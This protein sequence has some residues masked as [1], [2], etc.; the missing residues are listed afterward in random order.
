MHEETP[1]EALEGRRRVNKAALFLV[2][3]ILGCVAAAV[4]VL[5]LSDE[6]APGRPQ[7]TLL[8][9]Q[10]VEAVLNAPNFTLIDKGS[11]PTPPYGTSVTV[12]EKPDRMASSSNAIGN[13]SVGNGVFGVDLDGTIGQELTPYE[14][15]IG[16]SYWVRASQSGRWVKQ[17]SPGVGSLGISESTTFL[18]ILARAQDVTRH[19]NTFIVSDAEVARMLNATYPKGAT[20]LSPSQVTLSAVVSGGVLRSLTTTTTGPDA[21][22]DVETVGSV[23]TSPPVSAPT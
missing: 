14:V 11:G 6:G 10:A 21:G 23:G 19:G 9:H 1:E 7:S 22:T 4:I 5:W 12:I 17:T 18:R 16:S 8:I 13:V 15:A 3:L 2:R 20:H